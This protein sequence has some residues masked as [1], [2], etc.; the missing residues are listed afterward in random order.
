LDDLTGM[1]TLVSSDDSLSELLLGLSSQSLTTTILTFSGSHGFGPQG[2]HGA[3]VVAGGAGVGAAVGAAV[4]AGVEGG[5][6]A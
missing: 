5:G 4:G 1:M 3:A 6:L 2:P